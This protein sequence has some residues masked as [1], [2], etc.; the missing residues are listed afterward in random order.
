MQKGVTGRNLENCRQTNVFVCDADAHTMEGYSK[1]SKWQMQTL[2]CKKI[3]TNL[4]R[5][6]WIRYQTGH[7]GRQAIHTWAQLR[8]FRVPHSVLK[9]TYHQSETGQKDRRWSTPEVVPGELAKDNVCLL[10]F[11]KA[12]ILTHYQGVEDTHTFAP[13]FD[14]YSGILK[15]IPVSW[16]TQKNTC[17]F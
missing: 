14:A 11:G 2:P 12:I 16:G 4:H 3:A 5:R 6:K 15:A 17:K 8:R 9:E 10:K 13:V 1:L 7:L